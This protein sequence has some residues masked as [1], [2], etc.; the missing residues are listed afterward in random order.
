M[1]N[2]GLFSKESVDSIAFKNRAAN[3]TFLRKEKLSDF[4]IEAM[5]KIIKNNLIQIGYSVSDGDKKIWISSLKKNLTSKNFFNFIA[6]KNNQIVGFAQLIIIDNKLTFSDVELSDLV[7]NSRIIL[8]LVDYTF[9]LKEFASF[10]EVYFNINNK[11]QKS[12]NTFSHLG[13]KVI[14][15]REKSSQYL[16]KKADVKNYLDKIKH[17]N[18]HY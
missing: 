7:K 5:F 10:D 13:G 17:S 8:E 18:K 12:I 4:E 1:N 6:Y 14:Q 2:N 3:Y 15:K 11:N 9:T 16:L